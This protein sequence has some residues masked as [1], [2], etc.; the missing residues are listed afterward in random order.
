M[1]KRIVVQSKSKAS[2][3]TGRTQ[4]STE[5]RKATTPSLT[6]PHTPKKTVL[7]SEKPASE[8]TTR[9]EPS[10]PSRPPR[11]PASLTPPPPVIPKKIVEALPNILNQVK[12]HEK[13]IE[14]VEAKEKRQKLNDTLTGAVEKFL[15]SKNVEPD[16]AA[17]VKAQ[18]EAA[19]RQKG[20]RFDLDGRS[21]A[22]VN[23][24]GKKLNLSVERIFDEA[25]KTKF[26][27]ILPPPR[28]PRVANQTPPP[29]A[30]SATGPK[31]GSFADTIKKSVAKELNLQA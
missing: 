17:K 9:V 25:L 3:E 20:Y 14:R 4:V 5:Q 7:S 26:P 27:E 6:Q 16:K 19:L 8:K 18:A 31:P 13:F 24:N 15:K 21:V 23:E 2:P 11:Q 30:T 12:K 28:T 10:L 1:R 22:V 29:T